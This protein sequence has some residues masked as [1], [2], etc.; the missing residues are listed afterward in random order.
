MKKSA[1]DIELFSEHDFDF[2]VAMAEASGNGMILQMMKLIVKKVHE[3]YVRLKHETL[4]DAEKAIIT[5]EKTVSSVAEGDEEK[6]AD[7]MEQHLH[8]VTTEL[9]R[10]VSR[11]K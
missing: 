8:L 4:F 9:K 3:E 6:A 11:K 1:A 10:M 7:Y 2:H 5:A